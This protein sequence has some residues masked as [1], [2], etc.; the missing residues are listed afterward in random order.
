[1]EILREGLAETEEQLKGLILEFNQVVF[2]ADDDVDI[3]HF[4]V[5][6]NDGVEMLYL[7]T[8]D[9]FATYIRESS[10]VQ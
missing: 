4:W 8:P 3:T 2:P 7:G 10:G 1:M 9:T 6:R 5:T